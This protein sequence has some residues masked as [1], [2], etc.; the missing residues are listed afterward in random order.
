MLQNETVK[1]NLFYNTTQFI[2]LVKKQV[3]VFLKNGGKKLKANSF[4][5]KQK[6]KYFQFNY[7]SIYRKVSSYAVT[8]TTLTNTYY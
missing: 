8:F 6:F 4:N 5:N 7:E 2:S 1:A 3:N